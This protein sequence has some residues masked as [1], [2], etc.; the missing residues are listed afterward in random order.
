MSISTNVPAE[1]CHHMGRQQN[2]Q[3]FDAP[4]A[5]ATPQVEERI[6]GLLSRMSLEEKIGFITGDLNLDFGFYSGPFE[7][8]GIPALKMADG[9]AG[10]RISKGDVHSG[11][12]TALPAPIALAAT[13][14]P[15][16]AHEYG[17]V[18]GTE[19]RA[20]DHNISLGPAVD[21][22][23]VPIGGRTYESYGED[24]VLTAKIG[25][26][27]VRGVQAQGV[28][29][30]GKHFAMNNQE[31]DRDGISAVV[32][33]RTMMELYMPPFEALIREGEVASM[34]A[35]FN[36]VNGQH[37]T[38]NR[39]MLT[40]LLRGR[41]GFKGWVMSDYFATHSTVESA[42]AGLDQEQPSGE[43]WGGKLVEAVRNG[44]VAESVV[45]DKV[46]N[47]L[48]PL[49]GL[50]QIENPVGIAEFPIDAHHE[51]AQR[52]AEASMVLLANDGVLPLSGVRKLALI[53]ADVDTVG[54]QGGGSALVQPTKGVS[55]F[56]GLVRALGSD[57]EVQVA[58]GV[59]PIT[60]GALLTGP[61]AIPSGFFQ[62]PT[63]GP[64]LHAE[65]WDNTSFEGEPFLTRDDR[66]IDL[67]LGFVNFPVFNA[68]SP[69][70]DKLPQELCGRMS[71]R[72][73][74]MIT[75][76]VTGT[77]RLV[78]T[79]LG[80]FR[81]SLE[82]K[83][84]A[85]SSPELGAN[86][87]PQRAP[88]G[89][90]HGNSAVTWADAVEHQKVIELELIAGRPYALR[91]D[92]AAN[93]P[94]Q[95]F[96]IGARL[97]LGWQA[98]AGVLSPAIVEAAKL[99]SEA[100]VAVV[101][102]RNYESEATDRNDMQLPNGQEDLIKA[103]IAANRR[104]IVVVMTGSP[105]DFAGWGDRAAALVQAWYPGQ[106]QG[107]ALGRLL[108]GA[109][110]PQGRL[111]L[112]FPSH[113]NQ[114]IVIDPEQYPGVGRETKYTDGL[115]VGYRRYDELNLN[116]AFPFG[117]GLDYTSYEYSDL[118][119][120]ESH[121][122]AVATVSC[123]VRNVGACA[124]VEVVQL[125]VGRL[126]THVFTPAKQ[127]AAF[128]KVHLAAGASSRIE[129]QVSRRAVSYFDE[130]IGDW[131]TPVGVVEVLVGSSSRNIRLAGTIN[132]S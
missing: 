97:R 130:T 49:I 92:Y 128:G 28:Q 69:S 113:L 48:R 109:V 110:Q 42:N 78:L 58:H 81:F 98:P 57:V 41:F 44:L 68:S 96:L 4:P 111:P 94:V 46:R 43:Q 88:I 22:A 129:L 119:V 34:M 132:V 53:G 86:T 61:D 40:D 37:S 39:Y 114:T 79:T 104:T 103:V 89:E 52:V 33:K 1:S 3:S 6:E 65:Y 47:I 83:V 115:L 2:A 131:S 62:T 9:P 82:D 66:Q 35:A 23:R 10:L 72:Y 112:T 27:F 124:G 100:D 101:I 117:H 31:Y 93:D 17:A 85:N 38:E 120:A 12:A 5:W 13:W 74:G 75:V 123:T 121:D 60:T 116:P 84:V 95:G 127:L 87:G 122:G 16:L 108:T 21:I 15:G 36:R 8:L 125:Y 29:A 63:G 32:D 91:L 24:P 50:G 55:P 20:S 70:Y 90:H 19:C 99:A 80:G 102:V 25:V 54:A 76:P 106:A 67:Y 30:C 126:P 107:D 64:G 14:D 45:D 18:I 77:Y 59:D 26:A 105:I 73:T 7:R 51:M 56:E 71:V 118:N 11:R